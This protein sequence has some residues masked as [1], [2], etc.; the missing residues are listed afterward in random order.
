[1]SSRL[2]VLLLLAMIACLGVY[3]QAQDKPSA[4]APQ[5]PSLENL[6]RLLPP[7]IPPPPP[8]LT[9]PS[10]PP[11]STPPETP[12]TSESS[13]DPELPRAAGVSIKEAF[14]IL[15]RHQGELRNSP[16]VTSVGMGQDGIVVETC[17]SGKRG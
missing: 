7:P 11:P 3:V 14:E 12:A 4:N 2:V 17:L 13:G 5:P 1:M 8:Q 15:T 10:T 6:P 16:G 9:P